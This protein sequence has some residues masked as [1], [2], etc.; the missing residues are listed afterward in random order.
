MIA[1]DIPNG[2]RCVCNDFDD[3]VFTVARFR[4]VSAMA[5]SLRCVPLAALVLVGSAIDVGPLPKPPAG[6]QFAYSTPDCTPWDGS[7]VS[8]YL[9]PSQAFSTG[10]IPA[11]TPYVNVA[12]WKGADKL[13]GETFDLSVQSKIGAALSCRS[14]TDCERASVGT[15]HF[16]SARPDGAFEGTIDVTFPKRGRVAGGF[17]ATWHPRLALCG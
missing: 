2:R 13:P 12:V 11:S 4:K 15:V 8:I 14:N 6:Y 3:L 10:T 9:G 17:H 16:L 1:A 7:A 5:G